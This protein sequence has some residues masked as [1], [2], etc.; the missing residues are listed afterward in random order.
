MMIGIT[1]VLASNR[2]FTVHT[3]HCRI[4]LNIEEIQINDSSCGP[5]E[6]LIY[7]NLTYAK[8]IY[9]MKANLL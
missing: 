4:R 8:D 6:D 2:G 3:I 7:K 5:K 9:Y 1:V